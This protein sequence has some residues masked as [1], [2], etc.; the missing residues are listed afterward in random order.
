M[1][2]TQQNTCH[3]KNRVRGL[4]GDVE[5][6]FNQFF[7]HPEKPAFRPHWD[8]V[9]TTDGFC[10]SIELP[11]VSPGDVNVEVE[12]GVLTIS[13]EKK[14]DRSSENQ[15]VHCF[16]RRSGEFKR[17]VEFSTP[18]DLD[19]IE[20]SFNNGLLFVSIPKSEKVIPRKIEVK[21]GE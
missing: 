10:V 18:V 13:G 21:I 4:F 17:S 6:V 20:A 16:E 11:G 1:S 15:T 12:E 14:I 2:N 3:S 5:S 9:E 8:I 7:D 19:K